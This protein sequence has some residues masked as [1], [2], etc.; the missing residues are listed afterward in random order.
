[1]SDSELVNTMVEE[2]TL[3]RRPIVVADDAYVV[4]AKKSDLEA[5]VSRA[6]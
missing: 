2:P 4:G 5:F 3:I 6:E 1:M